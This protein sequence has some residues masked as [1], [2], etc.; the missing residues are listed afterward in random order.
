MDVTFPFPV[1]LHGYEHAK[2]C[3]PHLVHHLSST[4]ISHLKT[5]KLLHERLINA[6]KYL[7]GVVSLV[8]FCQPR[9]ITEFLF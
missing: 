4:T 8:T 1:I 2:V 5:H 9:V 7:D 3:L 6:V